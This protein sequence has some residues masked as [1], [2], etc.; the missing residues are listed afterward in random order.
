MAVG[1]S[2]GY[3]P[4]EWI[5]DEAEVADEIAANGIA[6]QRVERALFV[7]GGLRNFRR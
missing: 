1:L 3:W 2:D 5:E 6:K 7:N 4:E